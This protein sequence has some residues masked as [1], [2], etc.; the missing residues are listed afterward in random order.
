MAPVLHWYSPE[1][2]MIA[3]TKAP[4]ER[5]RPNAWGRYYVTAD[6]DGCG[7]CASHAPANFAGSFDR[8]YYAV[9]HQPLGEKE[10]RAV[11]AA[12]VNCPLHCIHDDGEE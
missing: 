2:P 10:E 5:L 1:A 12:M 9:L 4:A 11:Q 7:L 8:A 6:C 3:S